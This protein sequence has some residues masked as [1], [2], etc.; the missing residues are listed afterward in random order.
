MRNSS[1]NSLEFW[2]TGDVVSTNIPLVD[3]EGNPIIDE[4]TGL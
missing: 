4:N 3:S 2:N 1:W